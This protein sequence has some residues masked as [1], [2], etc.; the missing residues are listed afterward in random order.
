MKKKAN[1]SLLL[2]ISSNVC[3]DMSADGPRESATH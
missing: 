1:T 3:V 2:Q